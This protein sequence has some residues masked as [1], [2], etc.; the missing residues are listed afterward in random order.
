M[1]RSKAIQEAQRLHS[2]WVGTGAFNL[3]RIHASI[4]SEMKA[5][6][7]RPARSTAASKRETH[8]HAILL[9]K[10]RKALQ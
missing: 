8:G 2:I 6:R 7:E 5:N 9:G 1:D 3:D 4:R 10:V